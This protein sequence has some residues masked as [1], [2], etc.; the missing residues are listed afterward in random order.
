MDYGVP[1]PSSLIG[2]GQ[3]HAM[4]VPNDGSLQLV[5]APGKPISATASSAGVHPMSAV[6]GYCYWEITVVT[7]YHWNPDGSL[8][9]SS[10]YIAGVQL[11]SCDDGY[12]DDGGGPVP[13][14]APTPC[15]QTGNSDVDNRIAGSSTL[16]KAMNTLSNLGITPQVQATT[17]P[18]GTAAK[19]D[20]ANGILYWDQTNASQSHQNLDQVLFEELSHAYDAAQSISNPT[21]TN[22]QTVTVGGYTLTYDMTDLY[23]VNAF[24]HAFAHNNILDAFGS[25]DATGTPEEAFGILTWGGNSVTWTPGVTVKDSNGNTLTDGALLSAA[26]NVAGTKMTPS[27]APAT[28]FKAAMDNVGASCGA[29]SSAVGR[30]QAQSVTPFSLYPDNSGTFDAIYDTSQ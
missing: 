18:S 17:L 23:A 24:Y 10:S 26:Q 1:I 30:L 27:V 2:T 28:S 29:T 15:T 4:A 19:Y 14:P 16:Q 25:S 22:T 6:M 12:S 11:I 21:G 5:A 20:N 8:K 9:S 3:I 13:A 7:V